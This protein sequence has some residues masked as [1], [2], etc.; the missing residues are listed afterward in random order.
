MGFGLGGCQGVGLLGCWGVA[1]VAVVGVVGLGVGW[2]CWVLGVGLTGCVG[3]R[4]VRCCLLGI[5]FCVLEYH[6]NLF[7]CR[8]AVS[9][10]ERLST[11]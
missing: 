3:C 4:V 6:R 5:D 7:A 1:G 2:L 11:L 10:S 8:K 9:P